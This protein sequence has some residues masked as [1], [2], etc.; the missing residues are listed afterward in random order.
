MREIV[1][2]VIVAVFAAF[3]GTA[4]LPGTSRGASI[5]D[6]ESHATAMAENVRQEYLASQRAE[7][8][9]ADNNKMTAK[10]GVLIKADASPGQ[11]LTRVNSKEV[12][13][14]TNRYEK[15]TQNEIKLDGKTYYAADEASAK[16]L[17][18]NP[19]TRFARDPMTGDTLDKSGAITCADASGRVY[20][21][22]K[23]STFR[24]FL[25]LAGRDTAYGYTAPK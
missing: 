7:A 1:R 9:K 4:S 19:S 2:M 17:S 20:Y 8:L 18:L 25:A 16:N 10:N 15:R 3:I 12:N 22:E 24:D 5:A 21:F 14:A 13:M 23:D 11:W 6:T